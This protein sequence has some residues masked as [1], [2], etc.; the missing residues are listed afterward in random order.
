MGIGS[1]FK[2]A[3]GGVVQQIPGGDKLT[4]YGLLG[5]LSGPAESGIDALN[6][7]RASEGLP[8]ATQEQLSASSVF[9]RL[10]PEQ[11]KDLLI[12]NPN[13]TTSQGNQFF[14]PL[15]NTIR[16]L[17]SEFQ[18]GQ[19]GR[20][21]QLASE[22]S[23]QLLGQDLPGTDPSA[24]F[25]QGRELLAPQFQEDREKVSAAVGRSRNTKRNRSSYKRA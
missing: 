17:E 7:A 25:E 6:R 1:S 13:I 3:L 4:N 2:K 22:L 11:Q 24:R 12:N 23:G 16:L 9:S 21:E 15:T 18:I 19:R 14:D 8:P 10:T 20:Q 5:T